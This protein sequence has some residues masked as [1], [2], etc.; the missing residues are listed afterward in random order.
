M[1]RTQKYTFGSHSE[2]V[3][4]EQAA[5]ILRVNPRAEIEQL[6]IV[7]ELPELKDVKKAKPNE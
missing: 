6:P 1:K 5:H 7:E 2:I 3:T 4:A